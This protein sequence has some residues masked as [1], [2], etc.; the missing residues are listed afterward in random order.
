[1]ELKL[2]DQNACS[3]IA[4]EGELDLYN[5]FKLKELTMKLVSSAV[6]GIIINLAETKYIDS[7]GV[8]SIIYSYALCKNNKIGFYLTDVHGSVRRVIELTKLIGFLPIVENQEE[9]MR[10]IE[11]GQLR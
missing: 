5:A 11:I 1:M 8:G 3:I 9:A 10:K 6:R 7:S 4:V 2:S